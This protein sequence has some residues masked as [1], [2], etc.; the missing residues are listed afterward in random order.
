VSTLLQEED[1]FFLIKKDGSCL[2]ES[3]SDIER[4]TS[5]TLDGF[6]NTSC[7]RV[8]LKILV[9]KFLEKEKVEEYES[10]SK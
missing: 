8:P 4:L 2:I 6:N 3:Q 10:I 7:L 1:Y 5:D 9:A